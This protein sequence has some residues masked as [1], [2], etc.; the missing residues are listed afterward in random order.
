MDLSHLDKKYFIDRYV[1]N[2]PFCKRGNVSYEFAREFEFD[3]D[4]KKKCYGYLI[5]CKSQGCGKVSMHLSFQKLRSSSW[6]R[7]FI[8]TDIDNLI[9]YSRPTSF[10]TLDERIPRKIR[11]L[12]FESEQSQQA[13]LL[14][15][16]SGCLRKAIYELIEHEKA[17]V[18]NEKTGHADYQKSIKTLK[19][20]FPNVAPELFDV[21]SNIQEMTSDP[22]HEGSWE[23]WDSSKL[24]FLIELA[25]ATLDEMYVI[26]DERKKRLG[27]LG[28]LKGTFEGDKKSKN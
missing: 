16:A 22:L 10:F 12:L 25:K 21:L 3:W 2:C 18:R 19:E 20:K 8:N 1:Y 13:N 15:G 27:I 4:N 5:Q 17:I 6:P 14:V 28:Q 9:F 11:D 26:P 24:T 23:A 7:R